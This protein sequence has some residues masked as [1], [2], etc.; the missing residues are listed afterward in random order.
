M[1]KTPCCKIDNP[2]RLIFVPWMP[3]LTGIID[4]GVTLTSLF[5]FFGF[6][7]PTVDAMTNHLSCLVWIANSA[8]MVY[9]V[10]V[11]VVSMKNL[12]LKNMT[13]DEADDYQ[14]VNQELIK[15]L[16]VVSCLSTLMT[17]LWI[18]HGYAFGRY[19]R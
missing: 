4:L 10:A 14:R 5:F 12:R 8:A 11:E 7:P 17:G 19:R 9:P 15:W 2:N 13:Q 1:S 16:L 18:W 6:G 3:V